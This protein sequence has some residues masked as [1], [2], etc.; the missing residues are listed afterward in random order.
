MNT[1]TWRFP[2]CWNGWKASPATRLAAKLFQPTDAYACLIA[3]LNSIA[4]HE[5][6]FFESLEGL[7]ARYNGQCEVLK[8]YRTFKQLNFW[9]GELPPAFHFEPYKPVICP[10]IAGA[11]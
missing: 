4:G 7:E 10:R 9:R 5:V 8:N 11:P 2:P 1:H 3:Y 6:T